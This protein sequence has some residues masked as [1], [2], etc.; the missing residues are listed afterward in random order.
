MA[1]YTLEKIGEL[2]GVSRST[3]S[4]VINNH[5]NISADVRQRVLQ[6][7]RETGYTPNHAARSLA[8]NQSFTI[9]LVIPNIIQAVFTDPYYPL[10]TQGISA[11]CNR[12]GYT[13]A[14]FL[15]HTLQ[16]ERTAV[17]RLT[18]NNAMDGLIITADNVENPFVPLLV[19]RD[20]NFVY[21]GR[22]TTNNPDN[23][24]YVDVDNE[25]GGH[26]AVSHLIS[27]GYRRIGQIA[28][29][30]NTAGIDRDQG[31]RRAMYEHDIPVDES[32][33]AYGDFTEQSGYDAMQTLIPQEPDAVFVHS[34][35]MA[36]GASRALRDAEL[37]VPDDVALVGFDDLP[38]ATQVDVPL[39]TIRQPIERTGQL[40]VETLV[41]RVGTRYKAATHH[42]LSVELVMRSSC[43]GASL[44]FA[45][46]PKGHS[47]QR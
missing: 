8:S 5:P 18:Q 4:R 41:D 17:Q 20:V 42:I 14:L 11:A 22:P 21:V 38:P 12:L 23:I 15:F 37:A 45:H 26:L 10:L 35:S 43:G 28:T 29:A 39:T 2:A 16:E 30:H 19:E 25:A 7:I 6:V 24:T 47:T 13:L 1:K 34:D 44:N 36:L 46:E 27:L 31:F 40:A 9:G 33:V 3:V 32:L